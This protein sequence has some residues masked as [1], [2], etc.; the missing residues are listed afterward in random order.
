MPQLLSRMDNINW[1]TPSVA[2]ILEQGAS[3]PGGDGS[4]REQMLQIQQEL[5]DLE[6]P[7]R[8]TNV[9]STPS[10]TLYITQ[11]E[12]IGRLGNRRQVTSND[13]KRSLGK[14]AEAHKDEWILG[15]LPQLPDNEDAV[16]ILLR[17]NVHQPLSLRRM[18]VRSAYRDS[19]S[20][21][22][23]VLGNTLEQ[24]LVVADLNEIGSLL[25]IGT[26]NA[27]YHFMRSLLV[28][29]LSMNTPGE[30]RLVLAG[31]NS[32]QFESLLNS[33]H[34]VKRLL[35]SPT[36]G[37]RLLIGLVKE[38]ERRI[39]DIQQAGLETLTAFNVVQASQN[40]DILP[41]ILVVIDSLSDEEWQDARDTWMPLLSRL[42]E[43]GAKV[44]IH[45]IITAEKNQAPDVPGAFDALLPVKVIMRPS[46]NDY[47]EK[48]KNFHS[49]QLRFIDALV[50]ENSEENITALEL[51]AVSDQEL[52][53]VIHYW[54]QATKKRH[55]EAPESQISGTTGMTGVLG[56]KSV[57]NVAGQTG[58][59]PAIQTKE[60]IA[61]PNPADSNTTLMQAQ[62]LAAY[63]GWIG[64][65]PLHDVLGLSSGEA[66]IIIEQ[67][68]QIGVVETG[69][70]ATPRF[71]RLGDI[72]E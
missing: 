49:S 32:E 9:R 1:L 72:P 68:Q 59:N 35:Q 15:F 54:A 23:V 62:A 48:I 25:V 41:H 24:R 38:L 10:Y 16:G 36:D 17:T 30:L 20:T 3:P 47:V 60:T 45:T 53:N 57:Q 50:L 19:Q 63:L 11:P 44:G 67:L 43:D 33:P 34:A 69:D 12:V 21:F 13:L 52:K 22:A 4:I 5:S 46:A 37:Q 26:A 29:L 42:L 70:T 2:E 55:D 8:I 6:T 39:R 65:G 66:N 7:A 64:I 58:E 18:L 14:I 56:Q 28:T 40:N 61:S 31:N 51:C 71:V 27:K